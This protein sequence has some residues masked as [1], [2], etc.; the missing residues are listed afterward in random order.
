[1]VTLERKNEQKTNNNKT[2][3]ESKFILNFSILISLKMKYFINNQEYSI[4]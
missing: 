1:M 4:I 2:E 3:L